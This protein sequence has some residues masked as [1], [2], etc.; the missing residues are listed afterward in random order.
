M[1]RKRTF[2]LADNGHDIAGTPWPRFRIAAEPSEAG[3]VVDVHRADSICVQTREVV[4]GEPVLSGFVATGESVSDLLVLSEW[5]ARILIYLSGDSPGAAAPHRLFPDV[6]WSIREVTADGVWPPATESRV[7][8][9]RSSAEIER[10]DRLMKIITRDVD[11]D[12]L[13]PG[14]VA[15]WTVKDHPGYYNAWLKDMPTPPEFVVLHRGEDGWVTM[16]EPLFVRKNDELPPL[17]WR[18]VWD[19]DVEPDN[20]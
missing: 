3:W 16:D 12:D 15:V 5:L 9:D 17:P 6:R 11:R 18:C 10:K 20:Q 1:T 19:A 8:A 14:S 13:P 7:G 2:I 4:V